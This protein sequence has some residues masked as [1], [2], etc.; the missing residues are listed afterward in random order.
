MHY[1]IQISYTENEFFCKLAKLFKQKILLMFVQ[2]K[3]QD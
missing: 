3:F 1:Y 2:V